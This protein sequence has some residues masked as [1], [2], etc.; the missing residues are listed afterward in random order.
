MLIVHKLCYFKGVF[1]LTILYFYH[2]I[3]LFRNSFFFNVAAINLKF[4]KEPR[5]NLTENRFRSNCFKF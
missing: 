4:V 5:T 1:L 2:S 3:P